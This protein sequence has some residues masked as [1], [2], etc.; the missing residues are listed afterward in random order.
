MRIKEAAALCGLTEKAIRLYE[1]KGLI[2][3]TLTEKNGRMFRDYDENTVAALKTVA[4][5]RR[6]FF[7]LEQIAEMQNAPDRIPEIFAAYKAELQSNYVELSPLLRRAENADETAFLSAESVSAYM[8]AAET[9]EDGGSGAVSES[10]HSAA[11]SAMSTHFR[12]WDEGVSRDE[13]EQAY[14]SYL[15]FIRRWEMRYTAELAVRG[16]FLK[17][18]KWLVFLGIPLL[19]AGWYLYTQPFVTAVD[20]ELSGYEIVMPDSAWVDVDVR[21][22]PD[23]AALDAID[24]TP[25]VPKTDGIPRTVF[26]HGNYLNY[27][28]REDRFEGSLSVDSYEIVIADRNGII[29]GGQLTPEE[30]REYYGDAFVITQMFPEADC[31]EYMYSYYIEG[32]SASGRLK[33]E[34]DG[35][36][37]HDF[38]YFEAEEG[39]IIMFPVL[40]S[41]DMAGERFLVFP[42]KTPDEAAYLVLEMYWRENWRAYFRAVRPYE[43]TAGKE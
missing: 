6:A 35:S 25:Y 15:K 10:A 3:P 5:L 17:T 7:S 28:F 18:W 39:S 30:S 16:F 9:G 33:R 34:S 40:E 8:T 37:L 36:S 23:E 43:T 14:R 42:A 12:V 31:W 26:L 24:V 19:I 1:E 27:L 20:V 2:T 11:E 21:G 22:L 13:R 32:V 38:Y 4:A 29:R 41:E